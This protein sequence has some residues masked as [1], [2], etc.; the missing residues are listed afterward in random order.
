[1]TVLHRTLI[2]TG[3]DPGDAPAAL[4][5]LLSQLDLMSAAGTHHHHAGTGRPT[6]HRPDRRTGRR[7]AEYL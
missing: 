6:R 4:A 5:R 1:M 3:E 2:Q 7:S